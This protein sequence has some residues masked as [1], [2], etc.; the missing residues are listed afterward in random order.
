MKKAEVDLP[1]ALYRQVEALVQRLQL[2]VAELLRR[3]AEQLIA[4]PAPP[5]V[6]PPGAWRFPEGRHLGAFRTPEEDSRLLANENS[7]E[8][9]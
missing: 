8:A 6:V 5:P 9:R 4:R 2:T 1:D 3:A 7:T